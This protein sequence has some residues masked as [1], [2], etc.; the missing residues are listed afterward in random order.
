L[1]ANASKSIPLSGPHLESLRR[2]RLA[3][4]GKLTFNQHG[5][6]QTDVIYRQEDL[7]CDFETE[8]E[9]ESPLTPVPQEQS[10]GDRP[11]IDKL[12]LDMKAPFEEED[13]LVSYHGGRLP[14]LAKADLDLNVTFQ[15]KDVLN[16][17]QALARSGIL[18]SEVGQQAP[19][20]LN[21]ACQRGRN[22]LRVKK[23]RQ[24]QQDASMME[25]NIS[26]VDSEMTMLVR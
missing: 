16:D 12:T 20:W 25:D 26:V 5:R 19:V 22:V 10:Y 7:F 9:E 17:L 13:V 4:D 8:E 3:K 15:S 6:S 1:C 14:S 2:L 24:T 11:F 21:D 23:R 18:T